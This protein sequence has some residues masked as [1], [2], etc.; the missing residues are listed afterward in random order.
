MNIGRPLHPGHWSA[1]PTGQEWKGPEPYHLYNFSGPFGRI[2]SDL[3]WTL[4]VHIRLHQFAYA[5]PS[6][7]T[8]NDL[9][10]LRPNLRFMPHNH[11]LKCFNPATCPD[12][13]R[14][15][16]G[17]FCFAKLI[18]FKFLPHAS[19]LVPREFGQVLQF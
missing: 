13:L 11:H 15:S 9:T 18:A 16:P 7:R 2:Q 12:A 4:N 6:T 8:T 1:G 3:F 5:L 19:E 14:L 17:S 10:H